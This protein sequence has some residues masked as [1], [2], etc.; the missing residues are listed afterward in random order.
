VAPRA[1]VAEARR[2]LGDLG[3]T[4]D[5]VDLVEDDPWAA[6]TLD[7]LGGSLGKRRG[8]GWLGLLVWLAVLAICVG[9]AASVHTIM[10]HGRLVEEQ[11]ALALGLEQRLADL[12][13]IRQSLDAMRQQSGFVAEQRR[14]TASPLIVLEVLSRLL[15]DTVW[16]TD[17][18]LDP[19]GLSISG[20]AD[21]P[22]ALLTLLEGSPHFYATRFTAPSTRETILGPDGNSREMN[23]FSINCK[24]E[25]SRDPTP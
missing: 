4:P 12:P 2:R 6:P 22:P 19:D 16:L 1:S 7:L 20:Y 21:D 13:E 25:P 17:L 24:V 3:L 9:G 15:P 11:R 18:S 14:S 5:A 10:K 8:R 23:R